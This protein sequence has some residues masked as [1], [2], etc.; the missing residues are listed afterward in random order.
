MAREDV[1]R[2]DHCFD[3][4]IS[5]YTAYL[6]ARDG[7]E[8]PDRRVRRGRLDLLAALRSP[9]IGSSPSIRRFVR[10]GDFGEPALERA[11][12]VV[13]GL[14][15]QIGMQLAREPAIRALDRLEIGLV[16]DA[17]AARRA[18]SRRGSIERVARRARSATTPST[19]SASTAAQEVDEREQA[20]PRRARERPDLIEAARLRERG[21]HAA[22]GFVARRRIGRELDANRQPNAGELAQQQIGERAVELLLEMRARPRR[23]REL[24]LAA[25]RIRGDAALEHASSTS[26]ERDEAR[27]PRDERALRELAVGEHRRRRG[28]ARRPRCAASLRA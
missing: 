14:G 19:S 8:L 24:V 16:V 6:W 1:L 22:I 9:S 15:L 27:E 17:R 18:A 20:E 23:E 26:I 11:A 4:V 3:A 10:G 7:W 5:A 25:R 28:E 21:E 12:L 13:I 2:N